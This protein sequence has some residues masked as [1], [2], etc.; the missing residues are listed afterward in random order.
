MQTLKQQ[1]AS[2][3][4]EKGTILNE[5]FNYAA[6]AIAAS[7]AF[8]G[9]TYGSMIAPQNPLLGAATGAV[10]GTIGSIASILIPGTVGGFIGNKIAETLIKFTG[11]SDSIESM[12]RLATIYGGIS[13]GVG[14]SYGA[15]QSVVNTGPSITNMLSSAFSSASMPLAVSAV[16]VGTMMATEKFMNTFFPDT[17]P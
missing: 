1:V 2:M 17:Q 3:I 13:T 12:T 8:I 7:G 11:L 16:T 4:F 6:G 14:L 5:A 9:A 10:A 15:I